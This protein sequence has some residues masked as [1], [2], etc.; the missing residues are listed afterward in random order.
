MK[1]NFNSILIAL[2]I[3]DSKPASNLQTEDYDNFLAKYLKAI[4]EKQ[5]AFVGNDKVIFD[6]LIELRNKTVW[7]YKAL[8]SMF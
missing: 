4:K 3:T 7:A 5:E 8:Y 6:T 2:K 1:N